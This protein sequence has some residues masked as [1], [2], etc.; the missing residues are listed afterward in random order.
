MS[1][2]SPFSS[3]ESLNSG[4][5]AA[6]LEAAN[7][8]VRWNILFLFIISTFL[9]FPVWMPLIPYVNQA[10]N[11]V[12]IVTIGIFQLIWLIATICAIRRALAINGRNKLRAAKAQDAESAD[13]TAND[14]ST[15]RHIVAMTLYKEPMSVLQT[16]LD[17]LAQQQDATSRMSVIIGME[18]R[19]PDKK[20]KRDEVYAKYD[21]KFLRLIVTF[22]PSGVPGEIPGKCSNMN[23]A[24]RQGLRILRQDD[25]YHYDKYEHIFTNCDC[26]AVFDPDYMRELETEYSK[27]DSTNRHSS[28]WQSIIVYKRDSMPFFVDITG[29]L[30]TFF[31]MGVLI[32]WNINP[33]S[34]YSLSVKL[35]EEGAFTHPAYQM[36]DIIA[37]IRY[38]IM[39]RREIRIRP[40]NL[41]SI[42]GPTSGA[43]YADEIREWALQVRRWTI[44]AG[45]VFHYFI[46]K[47]YRMPGLYL[48]ISWATR[49]F[50]YY[51]LVLCASAIFSVFSPIIVQLIN[52]V[53]P[54]H[55]RLFINDSSFTEITLIFLG[56]QYAF[57][58]IVT[59]LVRW[60]LP[61]PGGGSNH[62][63][64]GLR[65]VAR[66][67][68]HWVLM[69][70]TILAYSFVELYS[71]IELAFRG[72]DV[73]KHNA[74]KGMIT[75]RATINMPYADFITV[76]VFTADRFSG[77]P[78]A[79][80]P[81]ARGLETA[82]MQSI[83][84]EF[85]YSES[86]FVLPPADPA[87]SAQVRIFT[88]TSEVPFAGHPNVGT[89]FVL[90]QLP[91]L[92]G[93]PVGDALLFEEKAGIVSVNLLRDDTT[94]TI[95]GATIRA[96]G[97]LTT[98]SIIPLELVARCAS[99][100]TS[101]IKIT[102]HAP[103]IASVGL[104]FA[105]AELNDL[106]AL[107][108]ARL[109][110]SAFHEAN[111]TYKTQAPKFPLFLYVR[112]P[113]SPW[114]IRA[115]MFA[116]LDDVSEDPATGSASAALGAYLVS[117]LDEQDVTVQATIEQGVEM[118]RGSIIR[119]E[120]RKEG[121]EVKDV[122][123]TGSCVR[124]MKGVVEV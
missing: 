90:G 46:V 123:V 95:T 15:I 114:K 39:T 18:S 77:N 35:L 62:Y 13:A 16:T 44:G 78:L 117:N 88:P 6:K 3:S 57:L 51:G 69:L 34:H 25:D 23:Y 67:L 121:G 28:I 72:K 118:G 27:L 107:G 84:K 42:N 93:I 5:S 33:M 124:V 71:F 122:Y 7:R 98:G 65:G 30:R 104:A 61:V 97:P 36:E 111:A 40:L 68:L 87:N 19:T 4:M 47:T 66:G 73:C 29:V 58:L 20:A 105:F 76:D 60:C 43:N 83:A 21:N 12:I 70:P 49:F 100:A 75:A 24:C 37:L 102:S 91:T 9:L 106:G 115:R 59:V 48:S 116:P 56:T 53:A 41:I 22:H 110:V 89:A 38:T 79:V 85:G 81:D 26:D 8:Y 96:P 45:E 80:I 11:I 64:M 54:H 112:N 14:Y 10:T 50:V 109:N 94:N 113:E 32:P 99:I 119:L 86:T 2:T 101:Q 55:D 1:S 74:A 82:D 17:S 63:N 108:Q 103:V 92:F 31:F 52:M 120:V